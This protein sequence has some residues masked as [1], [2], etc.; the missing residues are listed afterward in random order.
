MN[1]SRYILGYML[2][3]I[4]TLAGP[5]FLWFHMASHHQVPSHTILLICFVIFALL[6][7]TVQLVCFLHL[8]QEKKPAANLTVFAFALIVVVILVGG[9]LWIMHNL[10]SQHTMPAQ[11]PDD[12]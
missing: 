3:S 5:G 7:L 1:L 6:Q 4:L 2:S 12:L 9:T 8:G 11:L 10:E